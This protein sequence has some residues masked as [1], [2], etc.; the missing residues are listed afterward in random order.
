MQKGRRFF[1]KCLHTAF[2]KRSNIK[3]S[4]QLERHGKRGGV[5]I[6]VYTASL[7]SRPHAT[8]KTFGAQKKRISVSLQGELQIATKWEPRNNP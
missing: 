4:R 2:P 6:M 1:V 5:F 7:P 3:T 8:E